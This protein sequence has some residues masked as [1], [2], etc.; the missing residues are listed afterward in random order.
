MITA[1]LSVLGFLHLRN[2]ILPKFFRA[3]TL[4]IADTVLAVGIAAWAFATGSVSLGCFCVAL[5]LLCSYTV[6]KEWTKETEE[7]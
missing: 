2:D 5:A 7:H 4:S 6:H 1:F 3:I